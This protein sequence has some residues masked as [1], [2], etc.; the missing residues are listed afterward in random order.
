M[1]LCALNS[2]MANYKKILNILLIALAYGYLGYKIVTY[3]NYAGLAERFSQA[4]LWQYICLF[5]S[6]LLFPVNRLCEAW[7]W[8]FLVRGFE[9]MNIMEA[10]RQVYY[11]T[12]AGFVTPYKLGEYPGRALLFRHTEQHWLTATCLGMIGGY[13]MTTVIVVFG[14]PAAVWWLAPDSS[15]IWS[16]ALALLGALLA[17]IALPAIMR[18]LQAREWKSEQTRLLVSSMASLS[19]HDI[20]VLLGISL[21][22]Y[23]VFSLQLLLTLLFCGVTLDALSMLVTL[24]LYYLLIT[25][26]PNVPAA[27]I[28]VRGAWAVAIFERFGSDI[29]A[30]AV[31]A[32]LVLWAINTILPLIIGSIVARRK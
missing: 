11:G 18:R 7:K 12:I 22:R 17:I 30:A 32:T 28:A 26:T 27:E 13:A 20:A 25:V 16:I 31:I 21:V 14:L 9:P 2:I 8:Q 6:F 4:Q 15:L 19:Y 23:A 5:G 29:S 1:Y 3:D 24:P 10:Q